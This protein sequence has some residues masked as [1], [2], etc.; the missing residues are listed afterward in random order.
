M[1]FS[2]I[3][4]IN[5][6]ISLEHC[7]QNN[8]EAY[9]NND[10]NFILP[11]SISV[12]INNYRKWYKNYFSILSSY[13]DLENY[14]IPYNLKDYHNA[15]INIQ[16]KNGI[17]CSFNGRVKIH[18][19]GV[20]HID[21]NLDT[22]TSLR[23]ELFDGHINNIYNFVL[24]K[25]KTRNSE[26]ELFITALMRHLGFLSPL[27]FGVKVKFFDQTYKHMIFQERFNEQFLKSYKKRPGPILAGNKNR[28]GNSKIRNTGL[29]RVL[30]SGGLDFTKNVHK[31]I[32]LKA[33]DKANY[34]YLYFRN[35]LEEF[36]EEINEITNLP[37]PEKL[38]LDDKIGYKT[39]GAFE[40]I[41]IASAGVPGLTKAERRF[42]YNPIYDRL[43]PIYYD[44]MVKILNIFNNDKLT[45]AEE[46]RTTLI[47]SEIHKIGAIE[48]RLLLSNL[49]SVNLYKYL[50]KIRIEYFGKFSLK[51]IE[52]AL[53][54]LDEN[55]IKIK[56]AELTNK[57]I[58]PNKKAYFANNNLSDKYDFG[59]AFQETNN[60]F[61]ICDI[62]LINCEKNT[63]NENDFNRIITSQIIEL[64]GKKVRFVRKNL[65]AYVHNSNPNKSGIKM[66]KK[67]KI[68]NSM[69]IY[70][71]NQVEIEIFQNNRMIKI[72]QN[73]KNDYV[74]IIGNKINDWS[75]YFEGWGKR[76]LDYKIDKNSIGG[77]I[78]F[79]DS[80]IENISI[81]AKNIPCP[82]A[83]HFIN[84]TGTI[85][86]VEIF[87]SSADAFDADFSNLKVNSA[88]I[89]N[90]GGEC[91]G[92]KQGT[93]FF[94]QI[95]LSNCGDRSISSGENAKIT[96]NNIEVINAKVGLAAKDSSSIEA[97]NVIL[98]NVEKCIL[99]F[100]QKN[101]FSGSVIK[102]Y[103]DS[104]FC[105]NNSSDIEKN[106]LWLND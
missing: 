76:E 37:L 48:A 1:S 21:K 9:Q 86:D 33:L 96:L 59:L 53:N 54:V 103:N 11:E 40:A 98:K 49:D 58:E 31:E 41:L 93:Y 66:M 94:N 35:N 106:S 23:V 105:N 4:H 56:N 102:T 61:V 85:N 12:N 32:A 91:I 51:S 42:Y 62:N 88:N 79:L 34:G 101:N 30:N 67:I 14:V 28:F 80:F 75:F 46:L 19:S 63:L 77:C 74:I 55:L 92:V 72:K 26:N 10:D 44:G 99:S 47:I 3:S 52:R 43:E 100:K 27:T 36:W 84:T 29:S 65:N 25:P 60:I 71:D 7:N 83:I 6:N 17:V 89:I 38:F 2:D 57:N 50:K 104:Y 64:K 39:M 22:S 68:N 13:S 70:F 78:T 45:I 90:A 81:F 95:K 20:D 16:Y 69:I 5:K 73:S 87:N 82:N 24:F 15:R 97:K 8:L 18:G